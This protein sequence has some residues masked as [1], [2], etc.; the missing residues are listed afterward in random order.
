[1]P[2]VGQRSRVG[3]IPLLAVVASHTAFLGLL[4]LAVAP[5]AAPAD[6]VSTNASAPASYG[7]PIADPLLATVLGTPPAL[8]AAVPDAIDV[9]RRSL[10]LFPDREIPRVLWSSKKFEYSFVAQREPAP[11][12][13]LIAGTG[14]RFDSEKNAYLQKVL[15]QAGMSVVNISSPTHPDFII[16][17][18]R[19]S[20]P[21]F[22]EA[23][24]ED[25]YTVMKRIYEDIRQGV[26]V[27][28]FY[29]AGYSLGGT[30]AAYLAH[31]DEDERA[32][33]FKKVLLINPSVSLKASVNRLDNMVRDSIPGGAAELQELIDDLF[34]RVVGYVNA[35]GRE[36]LDVELL[37]HAAGAAQLT[38]Q[39]LRGLIGV[40]FRISLARML[41]S[42]DVMT[43]SGQLVDPEA[44]LTRGTPLLPYLKAGGRW[45]FSDYL[46]DVLL[47][48][49]S[50]RRPELDRDALILA[51]SLGPIQDYLRRSDRIAV[52]TSAD[53]PI[54]DEADVE[55]LRTTFSDR[56]IIYPSGGH[57][58]SLMYE[59]NVAQMLAFLQGPPD[60]GS[61]RAGLCPSA[62]TA[63]GD[64]DCPPA[65]D[66]R[67]R[68][69]HPWLPRRTRP[70]GG[71]EPAHLYL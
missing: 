70:A 32:F 71:H 15:Y 41:F 31:L 37:Y 63:G 24:V 67:G 55:F 26:D 68:S 44:K 45:S 66:P 11:L 20:V 61:G 28:E 8:R 40:A 53:D 42:S 38:R 12:I 19:S 2:P 60:R 39:E 36:K 5:V 17:A 21:G 4:L 1:M 52:I 3:F 10:T 16:T 43:G 14:A 64:I 27:S 34:E 57:C 6:E 50:A 46:D 25:L 29:I 48:F 9:E 59:E 62:R 56:A 18:S 69:Q 51:N 47:P 58:G 7:Y 23:D 13:F 22:M 49:W 54:L 33:D 35:Q 30:Q 65:R